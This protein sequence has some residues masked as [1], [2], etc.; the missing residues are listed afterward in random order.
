[1]SPGGDRVPSLI[2]LLAATATGYLAG[3]VPSADMAARLATH[4]A[5][6]LRAV[7]SGNPGAFNAMVVL[8][9]R[10]GYGVLVADIAKAAVACVAGQ[11]LAGPTGGH[12]AGTAAV[13]GHCFPVWSR[14]RGGKGVAASVGQCLVTFPAYV[15][16]DVGV[17][18]AVSIRLRCS[19][20]TATAVASA[21]WVAA[22]LLWWRRGWPNLWG[23]KPTVGLPLAAAATSAVIF[24]RLWAD[25][26]WAR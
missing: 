4:G 9:R 23:P 16:I 25:H 15:P 1:M 20:Y 2:R 13:V 26:P 12:L 6:D 24:N 14:F 3:S 8:G 21:A 7:G 19:D 22:S 10:W 11:R 18:W 17:A 5:T